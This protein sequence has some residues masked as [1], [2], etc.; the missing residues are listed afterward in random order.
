M[1]WHYR[2]GVVTEASEKIFGIVEFYAEYG[3]SG[4]VEPQGDSVEELREDLIMMLQDT[5]R[6]EPP[7]ELGEP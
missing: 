7:I 4:F 6:D 2:I 5:Y 1:T 3:P